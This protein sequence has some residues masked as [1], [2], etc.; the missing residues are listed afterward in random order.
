[1]NYYLDQEF[2]EYF[3]KPIPWLPTVGKFN[4]RYHTIEL[5]SIGIVAQDGREYY[6]VCNEFDVKAA[7]NKS[8][9]EKTRNS[10]DSRN[11]SEYRHTKKY[12]L[13]DNVLASIFF[14]Y[15]KPTLI[16]IHYVS[17]M[18]LSNMKSVIKHIGKTKKDIMYEV[19][20]FICSLEISSEY[21]GVGSLDSGFSAYLEVHPPVFYGY[22]ADYDW[23]VFCSLF[24]TMMDLPQGFPMYCRDLKQILDESAE[25]YE[26]H[27]TNGNESAETKLS[28][29]KNKANYPK[30]ESEHHA[31]ADAKWNK[32]LHDFLKSL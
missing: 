24:G 4:K 23:V 13:R 1:M 2:H 20:Q 32:K 15:Y 6:A 29:I 14:S 8:E 21:A 12:W 30:Q 31:L 17:D 28:W 22:Y 27:F 18:S 7:Y 26:D 11:V 10:G 3:K 5:I 16:K 9:I 25:V 19:N